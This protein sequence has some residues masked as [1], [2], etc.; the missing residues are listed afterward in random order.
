MGPCAETIRPQEG[1]DVPPDRWVKAI[2]H[3]PQTL[4][5][6]GGEVTLDVESDSLP[7]KAFNMADCCMD[8]VT[9][10]ITMN[11]LRKVWNNQFVD[12]TLYRPGTLLQ[13][14]GNCMYLP[15]LYMAMA[16]AVGAGM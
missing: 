5:V 11:T 10:S 4:L 16:E 14:F 6:D 7:L 15:S 8:A 9:L 13:G 3:S 12:L 2:N 1:I